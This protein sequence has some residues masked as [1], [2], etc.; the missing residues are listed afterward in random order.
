MSFCDELLNLSVNLFNEIDKR[1]K[2]TDKACASVKYSKN[3][4]KHFSEIFKEIQKLQ[5]STFSIY[6]LNYLLSFSDSNDNKL[7][8]GFVFKQTAMGQ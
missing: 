7:S 5:S 3:L 4:S 2:N 1:K 8:L 6:C